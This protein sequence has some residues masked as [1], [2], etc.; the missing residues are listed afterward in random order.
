MA[1]GKGYKSRD[2][3]TEPWHAEICHFAVLATA[4]AGQSAAR[5]ILREPC[6]LAARSPT[7]R[8]PLGDGTRC[9]TTLPSA[10]EKNYSQHKK[11]ILVERMN[12]APDDPDRPNMFFGLVIVSGS[13]FAITVL[14]IV[15]TTFSTADA[16]VVRFLNKNGGKLLVAEVVATL[17][18]GLIAMV[19]DRRQTLRNQPH[20]SEDASD[21]DGNRPIQD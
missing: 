20:D 19:L 12:S 4:P 5:R 17:A 11:H 9:E 16:P 21:D 6:E 13:I 2:R 10:V 7:S 1:L 8:P 15:A 3:H 18:I 14:S